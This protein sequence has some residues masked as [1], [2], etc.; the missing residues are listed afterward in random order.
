MPE[1]HDE[2]RVTGR[3]ARRQADQLRDRAR[4]LVG[5]LRSAA[6]EGLERIDALEVLT[7]PRP[8]QPA[9]F[10]EV[11]AVADDLP[12]WLRA[13][14]RRAP[15]RQLLEAAPY[16]VD[17][18]HL[19]DPAFAALGAQLDEALRRATDL[20]GVPVEDRVRCWLAANGRRRELADFVVE[21]AHHDGN[22]R[23]R[24]EGGR[25]LADFEELHPEGIPEHLL[26]IGPQHSPLELRIRRCT[27]GASGLTLELFAVVRVVDHDTY[28]PEFSVRRG[29]EP[30]PVVRRRDPAATRFSARWFQGHDDAALLVE[31]PDA[32]L[33]LE[34]EADFGGLI[35]TATLTPDRIRGRLP[36]PPA[37]GQRVA[38]DV[39][40]LGDDLVLVGANERVPLLVER[41]GRPAAPRPAGPLAFD[42]PIVA[43]EE[44]A[45][46]LPLELDGRDHRV[47]L[48]V[49]SG[50]LRVR[51]A[52]PLTDD[53][54]GPRRQ[55]LLREAVRT[56][57]PPV[58]PQLVLFSSYA[59]SRVTDSPLAIHDELRRRRPDLRMRWA[60]ADHSVVPPDGSRPV[61]VRSREWYEAWSSA[62]LVVTNVEVDRWFRPR[63]EQFVV[64]TFHGYPSK[65]MGKVLWESKNFSPRKIRYQLEHTA[66]T[67]SLILTPDEAMDRHYREQYD[68]TGPIANQGYPRNDALVGAAAD[69]RRQQVR[70]LL[71]V[72][73]R[74]AVLH[75]PTWRDDRATNFRAAV[76]DEHL[77]AEEFADALGDTH[78]LLWRGHRFHRPRGDARAVIDVTDHPEVNDLILA[79]D[80]AVLDYSSLRFDF[81]VTGRP[82]VFLVP[83]L[84]AYAG[85]ARG[86]L[87]PFEESAPGP[88]VTDTAGV[89]A[90]VRDVDEL[91]RRHRGELGAF[92][93]RF[94]RH[95]DGLA[96]T[97]VVD[98]ILS[99]L[100]ES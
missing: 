10:G 95:H 17:A 52:P 5:R 12:R 14:Q 49:E 20:L 67:W 25:I 93:H 28:P 66:Q 15:E 74:V 35:R 98:T 24:M 13:V 55:Q 50:E 59:G 88:F 80:V 70:E 51:L 71:G 91:L 18:E 26:E 45:G 76:A 44:L 22:V 53:E 48:S 78:V 60:V 32:D 21:R 27:P 56:N 84:E 3:P 99:L 23:T 65:T 36:R 83:D 34:V 85:D 75:A 6:R 89:V 73:D 97:R 81:A 33:A 68:W 57:P 82:I 54:R 46:R 72:G 64:Q 100:S 38:T 4:G 63:P 79:A 2:T 41:W 1:G 92:N 19:S 31:V 42:P 90:Q 11:P 30:W 9:R 39:M 69:A 96:A 8:P 37:A 94:N 61:L 40:L 62:G 29:G 7:G 16:L 87:H 86:F 58:D 43:G 77:D 47:E